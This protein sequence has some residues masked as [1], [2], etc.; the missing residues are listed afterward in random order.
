MRINPFS[1]EFITQATLIHEICEN[2]KFG[3]SM[4]KLLTYV[5][6][7]IEENGL[8]EFLE[9]TVDVSA[10]KIMLGF[11]SELTLYPAP[12]K[13]KLRQFT[14]IINKTDHNICQA[15]GIETT[16]SAELN[17][18]L[19]FHTDHL[20]QEEVLYKYYSDIMVHLNPKMAELVEY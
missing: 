12:L 3:S 5:H 11:D 10:L 19:K 13:N 7:K 1:K 8:I 2:S 15:T 20:F 6:L 9:D 4:A 17:H 14:N 18:R 16:L